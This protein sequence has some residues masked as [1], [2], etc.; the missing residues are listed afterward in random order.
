MSVIDNENIKNLIEVTKSKRILFANILDLTKKQYQYI[1]DQNIEQLTKCTSEKQE[2]IN[3]IDALD[4]QSKDLQQY[5]EREVKELQ[6]I[7]DQMMELIEEISNIEEENNEKAKTLLK[8]FSQDIK[9]VK[10]TR[11]ASL[12]YRPAK[13]AT[14]S[15]FFDKRR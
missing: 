8:S 1:I 9:D 5:L 3:Q 6:E 7:K 12:L 4:K 15:Y 10:K 2:K 11:Q 14:Q 13:P